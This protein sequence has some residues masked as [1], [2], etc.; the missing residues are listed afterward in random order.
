MSKEK[1]AH[2]VDCGT[3]IQYSTKKPKWCAACKK[4]K[5]KYYRPSKRKAPPQQ[6][7]KELQMKAVLNQLFP[8]AIYIDNGYYSF[9]PSPKGAPLQLDRYYPELKLA[10]GYDGQQ[11]ASYNP[12]MHRSKAAFEYLQLCDRL[13]DEYCHR[14]GIRL[15]RIRH[16]KPITPQYILKRLE[17][18]GIL[19]ELRR[20]TYINEQLG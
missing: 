19:D 17:A 16:D 14:L 20:K 6:S 13:K 3:T 18:E 9:L 8:H 7:K 1:I 15:I 5:P 11:H 10:F 4:K 2:C 12:Y